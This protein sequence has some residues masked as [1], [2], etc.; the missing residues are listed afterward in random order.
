[1]HQA[2]TDP[3]LAALSPQ[4]ESSEKKN[5][6]THQGDLHVGHV[7]VGKIVDVALG[8]R[9]PHQND[10]LRQHPEVLWRRA[11]ALNSTG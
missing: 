11:A 4:D 1:M 6:E 9:V 3:R 2:D 10:L 7:G 8:L 5:E